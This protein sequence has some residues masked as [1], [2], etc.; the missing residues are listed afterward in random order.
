[1]CSEYLNVILTVC[2]SGYILLQIIIE[3]F[4]RQYFFIICCCMLWDVLYSEYF[5]SVVTENGLFNLLQGPVINSDHLSTEKLELC[6][7]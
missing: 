1:M 7:L 3:L 2:F 6:D 4:V 5:Y